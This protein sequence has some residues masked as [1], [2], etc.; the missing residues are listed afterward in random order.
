[1]RL[2]L[3]FGA[4]AATLGCVGI[5]RGAEPPSAQE[6]TGAPAAGGSQGALVNM[7]ELARAN[8]ARLD[9]QMHAMRC[10]TDCVRG[11]DCSCDL[12]LEKS[13]ATYEEGRSEA[14]AEAEA[15]AEA[16][17]VGGS[18][19]QLVPSLAAGTERRELQQESLCDPLAPWRDD[20]PS[21]KER[22]ARDGYVVVSGLIEDETR[23]WRID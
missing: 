14:E 10:L 5:A 21:L 23:R 3:V 2:R 18:E 15:A 22:Y 11:G 19:E 20:L 6:R 13:Q 17:T 4:A 8:E 1:M 12:N 9:E 7:F 16:E